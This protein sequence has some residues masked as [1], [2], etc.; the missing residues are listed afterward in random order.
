MK[1]TAKKTTALLIIALVFSFMGTI[2]AQNK[3]PDWMTQ[4]PVKKGFVY[5]AGVGKSTDM[6]M[7]GE[8]ARMNALQEL[9]NS[10]T[11]KFE[12]YAMKCDTVLGADNKVRQVITTIRVSQKA[13]L[14]G[15]EVVE[16]VTVPQNDNTIVY[17]LLRL[18]VS[19]DVKTLQKEVNGNAKLKKEMK[20]SGLLKELDEL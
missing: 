7:A 17:L 12:T 4:L 19:N 2:Y 10:Y 8:K 13:T 18:D 11:G 15:V 9:T 6:S 1:T 16:K 20:K 14:T 5:G 3:T